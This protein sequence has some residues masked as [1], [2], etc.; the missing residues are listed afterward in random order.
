MVC[1]FYESRG[2]REDKAAAYKEAW[3]EKVCCYAKGTQQNRDNPNEYGAPHYLEMRRKRT[4]LMSN[5]QQVAPVL[6]VVA[7]VCF[8]VC[9]AAAADRQAALE[10]ELLCSKFRILSPSL[11]WYSC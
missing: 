9:V 2:D 8:G 11:A 6:I 4:T 1:L 3:R 7:V 5:I 10:H